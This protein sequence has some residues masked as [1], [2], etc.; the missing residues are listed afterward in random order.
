MC[1][2]RTDPLNEA[3]LRSSQPAELC[4]HGDSTGRL[5]L[6]LLEAT[7][8]TLNPR[9]VVFVRF[10]GVCFGVCVGPVAVPLCRRCLW[11]GGVVLRVRFACRR[12]G[13]LCSVRSAAVCCARS[14]SIFLGA[15][16]LLIFRPTREHW[17]RSEV[18]SYRVPVACTAVGT[19]GE[20]CAL[21]TF[22]PSARTVDVT[23][24]PLP[25]RGGLGTVCRGAAEP[26][27]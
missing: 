26:R 2:T 21:S 23:G 10:C 15:D 27:S 5:G 16:W 25:W 6:A 18:T 12:P 3:L 8:S 22:V 13:F 17:L 11:V 14:S 9:A 1:N 7:C 24:R 19:V 20:H 4:I